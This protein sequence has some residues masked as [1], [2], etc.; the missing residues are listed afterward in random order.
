MKNKLFL[1]LILYMGFLSFLFAQK[2]E[3]FATSRGAISG[4][5]AVSFFTE[6]KPVKGKKEFSIKWKDATWYFSSE[7]NKK[8][9][10][11]DPE[12]YAP[13]FGGYCAYGVSQNHKSPT[14]IDTWTMVDGKLY[15]NYNNE[16]K[17]LWL[18]DQSNLIQLANKNWPTLNK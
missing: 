6:Q 8:A 9:F 18:K 1:S 11:S 14:E 12:K 16:V 15:F 7:E 13:Q 10:V 17:Q 5:D 3:V 2:G 4:Y